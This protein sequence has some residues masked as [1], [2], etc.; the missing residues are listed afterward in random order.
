M[1]GTVS[2]ACCCF[3]F[4]PAVAKCCRCAHE[5]EDTFV[6]PL[7]VTALKRCASI[8][9][10]PSKLGG[11]LAHDGS[12]NATHH[13]GE[14]FMIC[15]GARTTGRTL[16]ALHFSRALRALDG[17]DDATVARAFAKFDK[18]ADGAVDYL[19]FLREAPSLLIAKPKP[20]RDGP[21]AR[22]LSK[23][24]ASLRRLVPQRTT[25]AGRRKE[26]ESKRAA[27]PPP[28]PPK[29]PPRGS[30]SDPPPPKTVFKTPP[31]VVVVGERRRHSA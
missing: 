7:D 4:C 19:E 31:R 22:S 30:A 2:L 26:A 28:P 17:A 27:T 25:K 12:K 1:G 16:D 21:L 20:K 13:F 10:A 11:P 9:R 18:D 6:L 8:L 5:Q 14:L 23:R 15:T 29:T 3:F 24:V